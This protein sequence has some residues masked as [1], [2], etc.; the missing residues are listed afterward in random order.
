MTTAAEISLGQFVRQLAVSLTAEGVDLPLKD[1]KQWHLLFYDLKKLPDAGQKPYFFR[2]LSFNWDSPYPQAPGL[3]EFLE[4]LHS[5]ASASANNPS[6]TT[7]DIPAAHQQRWEEYGN[8]IE[9]GL[10]DFVSRAAELA[11]ARFTAQA[12]L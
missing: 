10:K 6:F 3:A 5:T 4:A 7:I 8:A 9:P 2:K 1:Q 11:K 12:N